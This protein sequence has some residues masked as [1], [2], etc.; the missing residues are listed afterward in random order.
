MIRLVAAIDSKRG[1]TKNGR[2]PWKLRQELRYFKELTWGGTVLLGR[3]T[4]D[5]IGHPLRGRQNIVASRQTN[6]V[7]PGCTVVND[8]DNLPEDVWVVGGEL[9]TQIIDRSDLLYLTRLDADF[10]CDRFFP[11]YE[12]Q[13]KLMSCNDMQEEN[14]IK[15]RYE[16]W[17]RA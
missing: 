7:L 1:I 13:F 17:R 3:K 11:D 5:Y 6:L 4:Y 14:G 9:F 2:T 10:A 15:F 8:L 16:V 12:K